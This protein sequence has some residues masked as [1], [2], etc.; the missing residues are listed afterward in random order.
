MTAILKAHKLFGFIDGTR[1]CPASTFASSTST[2]PPQSNPLYDDWIAKDQA[3]MTVINAT[4]SPEAL[5]YVVGSTSSKQVWD[6]L[7]KLYSSNSRYN[8]VNL[9]SELQTIS[10]KPDESIDAYIR[11]IK[12]IKDKLADV[13]TVINEEDLLIYALNGLPTEFNTFRTAMRTRPQ[14]VTFE[15][16]HVLLK[17]E[18]SAL[19]K[20]SK[21][22]DL[23]NQPIALLTFSQSLPSHAPT[24]NNN[25]IQGCGCGISN[26][27]G[28]FSFDTQGHGHGSS[29]QQ[30]SVVPDKHPSCQICL[31]RGHTALDCFNR[32]NYNFQGCHPPHQLAAM[33]ASQNNAF[34]SIANSSS[35]IW[36]TDSVCNTRI[37]KDLHYLSLASKYNGEE[38]VGI[39][40]GQSLPISHTGCGTFETYSYSSFSLDNN[41]LIPF[42]SNQLSIQDKFSGKV[43]FQEPSINGLY[44][45]AS[46]ATAASSS[47]STSS[48]CSTVA[49]VA[50]K[51][52]FTHDTIS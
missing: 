9:K 22:D 36:L 12:E 41:C 44:P 40:S 1:P 11:R 37:A 38:Q 49:H 19:A 39:G 45:I 21:C 35:P 16:L 32:M 5:A 50:A 28:S 47:A 48:S 18:E 4:L 33:V 34:L 17:S 15:E 51:S 10:K 6:V 30:Q 52:S 8:V 46:R 3:L 43:L 29:Q 2:G 25:S 7:A 14:P 24:F 20:Q 23:F 27:H 13:S 26:G 42:H 31:R